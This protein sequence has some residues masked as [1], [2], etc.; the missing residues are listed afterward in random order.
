MQSY[1]PVC[2]SK[3]PPSVVS[4]R[5]TPRRE[6]TLSKFSVAILDRTSGCEDNDISGMET[7]TIWIKPENKGKLGDVAVREGK[8]FDGRQAPLLQFW[9]KCVDKEKD[10]ETFKTV[11]SYP[12]S[13]C[14]QIRNKLWYV[15]SEMRS[16]LVA[17]EK[18]ANDAGGLL[19]HA[20]AGLDTVT[21][22]IRKGFEFPIA[23]ALTNIEVGAIPY[24]NFGALYWSRHPKAKVS[25]V[26]PAGFGKILIL[27][28][29]CLYIYACTGWQSQ[30]V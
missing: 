1:V 29:L 21:F 7:P 4:S 9:G 18:S 5:A 6:S 25:R 30:V 2:C 24:F 10:P 15:T 23:Q 16:K 11:L 14:M 3:T 8:L 20:P 28:C 22:V 12:G 13:N 17:G 27:S 19:N 26:L